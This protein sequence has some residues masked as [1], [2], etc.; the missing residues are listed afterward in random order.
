MKR[1][2]NVV[3][4]RLA[5][6]GSEG[7]LAA[8]G[9]GSIQDPVSEVRRISLPRSRVNKGIKKGRASWPQPFLEVPK[10]S[11][12]PGRRCSASPALRIASMPSSTLSSTVVFTAVRCPA[13]L[14]ATSMA[15]PVLGSGAS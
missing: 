3:P 2:L 7:I 13:A 11:Y 15:A 5:K 4:C 12:C 6:S 8:F 14:A 10:R 9:E 1:T